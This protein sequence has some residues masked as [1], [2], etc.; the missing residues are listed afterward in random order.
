MARLGNRG[1]RLTVDLPEEVDDEDLAVYVADALEE[2]GNVVR[3][4]QDPDYVLGDGLRVRK[5]VYN[6]ETYEFDEELPT[7][8]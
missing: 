5:I 2:F 1:I 8:G 6:K 7:Q 4:T 3:D